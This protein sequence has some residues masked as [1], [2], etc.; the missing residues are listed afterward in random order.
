MAAT[1]PLGSTQPSHSTTSASSPFVKFIK[2]VDQSVMQA[3]STDSGHRGLMDRG[4]ESCAESRWH[5]PPRS[6]HPATAMKIGRRLPGEQRQCVAGRD[7]RTATVAERY[8]WY[9]ILSSSAAEDYYEAAGS[10]EVRDILTTQ[11]P[12][13]ES[14]PL[15]GVTRLMMDGSRGDMGLETGGLRIMVQVVLVEEWSNQ[16]EAHSLLH[17]SGGA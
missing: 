2:F 12:N 16:P 5:T 14:V 15:E 3:V 8:S 17:P 11:K 9:D 10:G 1:S 13:R 4:V 7:W 6:Y